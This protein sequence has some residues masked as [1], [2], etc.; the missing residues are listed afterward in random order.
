MALSSLSLECV[1]LFENIPS[2]LQ[3]SYDEY[4]QI[5]VSDIRDELGRFKVWDGNVGASN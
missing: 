3:E 5:S 4:P 1:H 2:H